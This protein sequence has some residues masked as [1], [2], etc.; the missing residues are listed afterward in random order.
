MVYE[1]FCQR[2]LTSEIVLVNDFITVLST[3]YE[4]VCQLNQYRSVNDYDLGLS[5]VS[6]LKLSL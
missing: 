5:M 1:E 2:V 4:M 6:T 3:K